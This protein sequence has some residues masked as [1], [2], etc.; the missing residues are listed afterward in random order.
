MS[1]GNIKVVVR[2][3]PL[4]SRELARGAKELIRMDGNQTILEPDTQSANARVGK[5]EPHVFS[6]DKSYWSAGPRDDP[7][8]ASQ[9]TLYDDLGI[10]LLDHSF[11]G[12]NCCIFAY[13]Q[14]GSGK[15]YSMMGYGADKGIIP[16]TTSELFRR[17]EQ[18]SAADP[19]LS[20]SVEVSYMEIYNEKVRDLLNPKNKGNLKV[21]EH[22]SLGPYVEDLSRL[23]V[24]NYA[25][26]MTLMDEGNKARTV[27][28]TNMNETSSRSHAV[29]TL[30]LTQKRLE[31]ATKMTG[32]KVSK[33]SL[34]DLAGSERQA[35]TGATG[36]RLK[37]GANINRSLTTLGKV[38]AALAASGAGAKKK[39]DDFLGGKLK[40][41]NDRGNIVHEE[42]LSTLRYADAAKKIKTHAVVNEDPNAKLIRELKEELDEK[43]IVTYKTKEGEIRIVTKLEL[44]DQLQA[45]E[46]LMESLNLTWEEK[47]AKTQAIQVER[48]QALEELGILIN[49]DVVGV[50]APQKHPSLVNLNEDPLMSECL[51]Y[52]LKPGKTTAGSLDSSTAHVKLSGSNIASEHCVFV[53]E[54]GVVTVEN[55]G[56]ARTFV[57]GKRVAPG[58]PV[59]LLNGYRV[60]LGDF[61]VFRFNDP[62]A[63]R[64]Q[65]AKL[66]GSPLELMDWSAAKREVADIEKM[67]DQDLDKLFDDI[68]K[69]RTQRKRP[70]SRAEPMTDLESRFHTEESDPLA[71]PWNGGAN[72]SATSVSGTPAIAEVDESPRKAV[73]ASPAPDP[74]ID[75]HLTKQLRT[76]AQE[77]KRMRSQAAIA[78]LGT[79]GL[80]SADWT[81][82]QMLLARKA[83]NK[84]HRLQNYAMAERILRGAVE[85]REANT[86]AAELGKRV[87]YNFAIVDVTGTSSLDDLGGV[88]ELEDLGGDAVR[89]NG[90]YVGVKALDHDALA[91]Y[92][93]DYDRF[94][95][96]LSRMRQAAA[97]KS[98]HSQH[99]TVSAPFVNTPSPKFSLVGSAR[100]PLR[101]LAQGVSYTAT[102]P[103]FCPYTTEA[104]GSCRVEFRWTSPADLQPVPLGTRLSFTFS[105]SGVKGLSSTDFASIHAQS[106]LSTVLGSDIV[107][108]DT[109][110]SMPVDLDKTSVAHLSLRRTV[111]ATATL[112]VLDHFVNN[113]A[114]ILFF[115]TVQPSYLDRLYRFDNAKEMATDRQ[116]P[117]GQSDMRRS[118]TEFVAIE[119]HDVLVSVRINELAPDGEYRPAEVIDDVINLHQGVQRQ[120]AFTLTHSSGRALPWTTVIHAS[121]G[122]VRTIKGDEVSTCRSNVVLALNSSTDFP[123]DGTAKLV[124]AGPWDTGSYQTSSLNRRTAS[125]M[126]IVV[127]FALLLDIATLDEPAA[128]H[129]DLNLKIVGRDA[130]RSSF[131]FSVWRAKPIHDTTS[132]YRLELIPPLARSRRDM[133]RLDTSGKHVRGQ[134]RLGDW[135][136]RG[137]GLVED[138]RGMRRVGRVAADVQS[139]RWVLDNLDAETG[140]EVAVQVAEEVLLGRCVEL[141]EREMDER[142]MFDA[143]RESA[144]DE[145]AYNK[146]KALVPE[147]ET[148]L[149]PSIEPV[150]IGTVIAKAGQLSA[151]IHSQ[152]NEWSDSFFELRP[153]HLLVRP[154][155]DAKERLVIDVSKAKTVASPDVEML[156]GRRFAFTVFTPTNSYILQAANQ[157]DVDEW[158]GAIK[159][160]AAP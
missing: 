18:R 9:Q 26:M 34:V 138:W 84:W 6:F 12:F 79:G 158:V 24:E 141:W 76:L 95:Q 66:S 5:R 81:A 1:G 70:D 49:K 30:I 153:P 148:K 41:G 53:N 62:G 103:I 124:A 54:D 149:V 135:R 27:A 7:N 8:Y 111:T 19:N 107:S 69:V 150:R 115:A 16:L 110:A 132:V 92:T 137:V 94:L 152:K 64:A 140:E 104:I 156:L 77:M 99:F 75:Q 93:W 122:N 129:F 131:P 116:S 88:V 51:V 136:P 146:L 113:Y 118:E 73:P 42:T 11:E 50:H 13:G 35:S 55:V 134:E 108:E 112:D 52:Q 144:D 82:E 40:N 56:D 90:P 159:A 65:R 10:D 48:E 147:L 154:E 72:T 3:R 89:G 14:T 97:V 20:Y 57:N 142:V 145:A 100:A 139:T 109:L 117:H 29:F 38:I 47:M 91:V 23:V 68:V 87:S 33:I 130:K 128:F 80:E 63:V 106:R 85:L 60:I 28:S 37:E 44:Q 22:P 155:K 32:E 78:R 36:T 96:Q 39:K 71:N 61:H 46:K 105:V 45:S 143:R 2:C 101:L 119:H 74:A 133:W 151:L 21:R 43:Q 160:S 67:G 123:A 59:Q 125:D 25:Q 127:H 120:I 98:S 121:S 31:P 86:I 126:R 4:N 58:P 114:E 15:S 102:V 157:K 17:V 83:V